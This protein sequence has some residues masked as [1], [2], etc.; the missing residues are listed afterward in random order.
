MT[1]LASEG[2]AAEADGVKVL[3]QSPLTVQISPMEGRPG[4][5]ASDRQ[6]RQPFGQ[7]H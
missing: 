2:K 7:G 4:A 5:D 6:R 3:V 1:I